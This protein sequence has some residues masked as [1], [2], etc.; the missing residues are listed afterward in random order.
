MNYNEQ[1]RKTVQEFYD[2][3][4]AFA[5]SRHYTLS[6]WWVESNFGLD[7]SDKKVRDDVWEMSYSNDFADL[8]QTIDFDDDKKEVLVMIWASNN[9]KKYTI[10]NYKEFC[11]NALT[12]PP[13]DEF[14][15]GSIDEQEWYKT[16]KIHITVEKH[17]MELDYYA[18]NVTEIYSALKEMYEIEKEVKGVSDRK[19]EED[20]EYPNATWKDI[21]R[22]AVWYGFCED[23][24]DL[25]VEINKCITNFYRDTF[26]KIMKEIEAQT[27]YND[28]LQVNFYKLETQDLW[29]LFDEEERRKAFKEILCSKIEIEELYDKDGKCADKVVITDY[30]IHPSGHLVGWHYGVDWDKDSE[31]NQYYIQTYI[32]GMTK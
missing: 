28:E 32:E 26:T 14:N 18:D 10:D 16:H 27:S 24:H 15:D 30:S 1:I 12:L 29:K 22:F 4:K 7:L 5:T 25:G 9:K 20:D 2:V 17:D 13:L 31:D 11:N 19:L 3:T 8:I 21:L 23:S 6:Y